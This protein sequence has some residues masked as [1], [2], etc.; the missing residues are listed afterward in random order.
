M[1]IGMTEILLILIVALFVAGPDK[2]P[3]YMK[4][5]GEALRSIRDI[6]SEATKEI[7]ENVVEPLNEAQKPLREAM[8]PVTEMTKEVNSNVREI[9]KSFTDLS[10]P[11]KAEP[12]KAKTDDAGD[13]AAVSATP[14]EGNAAEAQP[15]AAAT[16]DISVNAQPS[17]PTEDSSANAQPS[18]PTGERTDDPASDNPADASSVAD[19]DDSVLAV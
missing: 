2:L 10:K 6:S 7:R 14:A 4:K 15:P 11:L 12:V 13:D 3:Y 18:A 1:K 5:F 9:K 8:E 16:E 17:A 19:T